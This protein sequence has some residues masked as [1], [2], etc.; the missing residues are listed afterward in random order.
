MDVV[1]SQPKFWRQVSKSIFIASPITIKVN[2]TIQPLLQ[3][4]PAASVCLLVAED[5]YESS[6]VRINA[7]DATVGVTFVKQIYA[8]ASMNYRIKDEQIKEWKI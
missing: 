4:S 2:R 7:I 5:C 1:I 3:D 8:V 6:S